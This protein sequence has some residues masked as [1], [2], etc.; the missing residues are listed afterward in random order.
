MHRGS[1]PRATVRTGNE[2]GSDQR[3]KVRG[4]RGRKKDG[5]REMEEGR[6]RKAYL[7]RGR[8]KQRRMKREIHN[9]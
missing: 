7:E 5:L 2:R 4:D 6:G 3:E 1:P 9:A 8:L